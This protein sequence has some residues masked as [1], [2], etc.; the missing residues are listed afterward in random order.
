MPGKSL[1]LL[2]CT[3]SY[4]VNIEQAALIPRLISAGAI[5]NNLRKRK[6]LFFL[7]IS[8]MEYFNRKR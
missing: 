3:K 6:R 5:T 4:N 7:L 8:R 2:Q 1:A